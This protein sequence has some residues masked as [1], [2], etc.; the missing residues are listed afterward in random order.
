MD[1]FVYGTLRSP[2]L[3]AAV[4]GAP[5]SDPLPARLD[6]HAVHPIPGNVVPLIVRKNGAVA[7]GV[8]WRGLSPD[9]LARLDVYEG[10]FGYGLEEVTVQADDAVLSAKCYMP[11]DGLAAAP[12]EWSL[13]DWEADH[14]A[15]AVL[16]AEE[17]FAHR[18]LPDDGALRRWLGLCLTHAAALPAKD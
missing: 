12:G 13:E 14:L 8:V 15:P 17:L 16:A 7:H 3:M 6:H 11:P 9:Q 18:P 2:T 1:L 4:A 10:A 5:L